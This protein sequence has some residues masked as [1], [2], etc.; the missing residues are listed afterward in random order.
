MS[1]RDRIVLST[2]ISISMVILLLSVTSVL[3]AIA[4]KGGVT[5]KSFQD[6]KG[7]FTV[8]YPSNWVPTKDPETFGPIAIS[9][10]YYG[11]GQSFGHVGF[12][13][14]ANESLFN[15][16]RD[17]IDS[18]LATDAN[19]TMV[20]PVECKSFKVN[21]APACSY[22]ESTKTSDGEAVNIRMLRIS[23]VDPNGQEYEIDYSATPDL[24][25]HF[26]PVVEAM[27]KSFKDHMTPPSGTSLPSGNLTGG[28]LTIGG[29]RNNISNTTRTELPPLPQLPK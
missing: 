17:S 6:K 13:K 14:F 1:I 21:G 7:R 28:N 8:Q 19:Y 10:W 5:W 27:V 26:T 4:Q 18:L 3:P 25:K 23:A 16:A 22:I 2:M 20:R 15:N 9:F 24:F 29:T 12:F 11:K